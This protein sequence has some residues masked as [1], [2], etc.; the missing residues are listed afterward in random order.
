MRM[1]TAWN[2]PNNF[3]EEK[4]N[5]WGKKNLQQIAVEH[6]NKKM[7]KKK[8]FSSYFTTYTKVNLRSQT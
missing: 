6:L 3:E 2:C 5:Q 4:K 1:K 7:K 8:K